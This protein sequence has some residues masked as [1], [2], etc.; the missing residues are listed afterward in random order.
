MRPVGIVL[1]AT[2]IVFASGCQLDIVDQARQTGANVFSGIRNLPSTVLP[3]EF[4]STAFIDGDFDIPNASVQPDGEFTVIRSFFS[5]NRSFNLD[6]D[7]NNMFGQRRIAEATFGKSYT[8]VRRTG[9]S[10]EIEPDSLFKVAIGDAPTDPQSLAHNEV[11]ERDNFADDINTQI[12]RNEDERALLYVHGFN[13]SFEEAAESSAKLSYDLGFSGTP[14]FFSW[15]ASG[16]SSAYIADFEDMVGSQRALESLINDILQL[17]EV[18]QLYV[19]AQGMGANLA[20]HAL[21]NVFV[22]YP[23]FRSRVREIILVA[24]DIEEDEFSN[25]LV[26]YIGSAEHPLTLYVSAQDAELDY[27]KRFNSY[28]L[29]GDSADRVLVLDHVET[30]DVRAASSALMDAEGF[31]DSNSILE[32]LWDLIHNGNRANSRST[33]TAQYRPE[34]THWAYTPD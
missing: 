6:L 8:I 11:L 18:E 12:S 9:A 21:K 5:T 31:A 27:S 26:P 4:E 28:Q 2:S 25:E 14:F 34:G 30:I 10:F 17:T 15:P 22:T 7:A 13:V 33:L 1:I 19:V 24:P 16:G 20:S 3:S 23:G 29:A 32:D